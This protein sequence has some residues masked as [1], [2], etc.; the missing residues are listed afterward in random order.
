MRIVVNIELPGEIDRARGVALLREVAE[1]IQSRQYLRAVWQHGDARL[2][3]TILSSPK[4]GGSGLSSPDASP[5]PQE[6]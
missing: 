1:D 2:T 3:Y 6:S 4:D 5:P